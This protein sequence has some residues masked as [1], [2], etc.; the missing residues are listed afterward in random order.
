M[1]RMVKANAMKCGVALSPRTSMPPELPKLVEDNLV[2]M[3]LVMTVEPGFGG[4]AF[5]PDMVDKVKAVR[6][7]CGPSVRIQVRSLT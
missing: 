5:N 7:A 1:A 3:V 2:D 4:Q 6:S